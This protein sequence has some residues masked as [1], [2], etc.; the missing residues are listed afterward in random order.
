M[1]D[2]QSFLNLIA[3]TRSQVE[4]HELL[5]RK[6]T[7][8]VSYFDPVSAFYVVKNGMGEET[9]FETEEEQQGYLRELWEDPLS[10][11]TTREEIVEIMGT[12]TGQ[13]TLAEPPRPGDVLRIT[14][15]YSESLPDKIKEKQDRLLLE[16][17]KHTRVVKPLEIPP[18]SGPRLIECFPIDV[19]QDWAKGN[20][21]EL[22]HHAQLKGT[23]ESYAL[24]RHPGDGHGYVTVQHG[25]KINQMDVSHWRTAQKVLGFPEGW[26]TGDYVPA[27]LVRYPKWIQVVSYGVAYM[28]VLPT[29]PFRWLWRNLTRCP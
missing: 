2:N 23:D 13:V 20:G 27:R 22:V 25:N 11:V 10:L 16:Q 15:D 14:Y 5:H 21:Y 1:P 24:Y 3:T 17:R 8:V 19:A 7:S 18:P 9:R 12:P 28:W 26:A 6:A 4:K 29:W